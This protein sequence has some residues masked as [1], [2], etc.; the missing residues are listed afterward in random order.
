MTALFKFQPFLTTVCLFICLCSYIRAMFPSMIDRSFNHGFKG[1]V[2]KA[3][4]IGDR[5]SPYVSA[6]CLFFAVA[7]IIV[8]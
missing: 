8:R 3:A 1:M 7:N 5:L 2:Y 6:A 4:V